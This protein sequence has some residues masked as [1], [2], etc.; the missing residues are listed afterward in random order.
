MSEKISSSSIYLFLAKQDDWKEKADI[1]KNNEITKGEMREYLSGSDFENWCGVS[2]K[3][4]SADVFNRFWASIDSNVNNNKLDGT[5]LEKMEATISN[6]EKLEQ[7]ISENTPNGI[8]KTEFIASWT[9][10]MASALIGVVE[11]YN[12]SC[13]KSL[14][15]LLNEALPAAYNKATA[16]VLADQYTSSAAVKSLINGAGINYDIA[17]DKTL[18]T[19][20]NN[21]IQAE[22]LKVGDNDQVKQLGAADIESKIKN[23]INSYLKTAGLGDCGT[24]NVSNYGY[25]NTKLNDAQNAVIFKKIS[26]KLSEEKSRFTGY[27]KEF[28]EVLNKFIESYLETS[29]I[30]AAAGKSLFDTLVS[31][32][33]EIKNAFKNSKEYKTLDNTIN[34]Y[35]KYRDNI[36]DEFKSAVKTALGDNADIF[37][38]NCKTSKDYESVLQGIIERINSGDESL[39]TNGAVDWAKVQAAVVEEV[40]S[41]INGAAGGTGALDS[42]QKDFERNSSDLEKAK[43]KAIKYCDAAKAM[44]GDYSA[45]VVKVFGSD[46]KTAIEAFED[47]IQLAT[48]MKTLFGLIAEINNK[49]VEEETAKTPSKTIDWS[50]VNNNNYSFSGYA[51]YYNDSTEGAKV[52]GNSQI[53]ANMQFL[54]SSNGRLNLLGTLECDNN[55][56]FTADKKYDWLTAIATAKNNFSGFVDTMKSAC[57]ATG[58]YDSEALEIAANK[59]KA[60]YNMA[61][62][63]A[64]NNWAGKKSNNFPSYIYDGEQYNYGIKKWYKEDTACAQ[65]NEGGNLGLV[66]AEA[67]KKTTFQITVDFKTVMDLFAKFYEA[68]LG[69]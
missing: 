42:L 55:D 50:S 32:L 33:D 7:L 56:G 37:L 27:E 51:V 18:T 41:M 69:A 16:E 48:K 10:K 9:G 31:K 11:N 1:N 24:I 39:M 21:Y 62:D 5:E 8:V 19:I 6:Y 23:L 59:V 52:N 60:L 4:I 45:A 46:H 3:D 64:P 17:N 68:A 15:E 38:N 20:V 34:V 29:N 12:E 25:D 61:F 58:N 65:R 54:Y 67:Y 66:F 40:T 43:E 26:D 57:A 13:G 36:S 63:G 47:T 28:D 22:L 14:E 30:T 49:V 2:I 44:G 53:S 35:K